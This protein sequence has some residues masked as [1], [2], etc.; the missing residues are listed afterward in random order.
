MRTRKKLLNPLLGIALIIVGVLLSMDFILR[1]AVAALGIFL[2]IIG[3]SLL[4]RK[5]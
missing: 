2:I 1:F 5:W 4:T 3:M